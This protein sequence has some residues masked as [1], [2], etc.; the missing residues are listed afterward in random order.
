MRVTLRGLLQAAAVVTVVFSLGTLLPVDHFAIQLFTHFR[1]QYTII[2]FLLC[3]AFVVMREG[4][5]AVVLLVA[6]AMNASFVIPWYAD[7]A[8]DSGALTLNVLNA[9][10]HASNGHHE[11]LLDLIAAEQP[12]LIVLQEVTPR[13]AKSLQHL[14]ADY[15]HRLVE[16]REGAFGSALLSQFPLTSTVSVDSGPDSPPVLVATVNV[17]GAEITVISAHP[18]TP[19]P[20]R[21]YEARNAQLE[22][23][24]KLLQKTQ[25]PRILIGD[26]NASMWDLHYK[27]LENRTWLRNV[28][29]GFGVVPTWPTFLPFAM[30]PIDHVLVSE[31]VGVVD[32]RTGPRIG[33]DHLPL[34]VTLTL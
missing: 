17:T 24:A 32:V 18:V 27:S 16:P 22:G 3:I 1:L 13:W 33:S 8:T 29:K 34:V 11:K 5:Y 9:N 30:I 15:P 12:D 7:A 31:D 25:N 19:L 10:V 14:V 26:L 21:N 2:A 20:Q 4:W 23:I 6:A 28:R